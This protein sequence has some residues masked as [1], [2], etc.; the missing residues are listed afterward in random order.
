MYSDTFQHLLDRTAEV[1]GIH[2]EYWDIF[3]KHHVT[4]AQAK[5]EILEAMG[6]SAK[7][8]GSLEQ[9]SAERAIREWERLL[10]PAVV[11]SS[12]PVQLLLSLPVDQEDAVARFT[13]RPE[14]GGSSEFELSLAPLPKLETLE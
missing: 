13:I 6:V 1:C 5:Q 3:G 10:P 4:S 2:P 9:S 12:G 14:A 8:A 11:T 7:D